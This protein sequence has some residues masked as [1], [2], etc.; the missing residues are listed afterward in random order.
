MASRRAARARAH[1]EAYSSTT[2]VATR[3]RAKAPTKAARPPPPQHRYDDDDDDDDTD[4]TTDSEAAEPFPFFALPAEIRLRVYELLLA[5]PGVVDLNP[6][7]YRTIRRRTLPLFLTSHRMHEEAYRVFY[8]TNVFRIF[9][10]HGRFF[11]TK[12]PL[13]ARLPSRY[14]NSIARLELRLGPG[15]QGPLPKCWDLSPEGAER[16]GLADLADA[17]SLKVFVECDPASDE[18][19]R[20]FRRS[21]DFFT[22]FCSGLLRNFLPRVPSIEEVQFDGFPSVKQDS[23]LM[24]ELLLQVRGH[25]KRV[26]YGPERGWADKVADLE[27]GIARLHLWAG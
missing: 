5:V 21:D 13:L 14:R 1:T 23:P 4:E 22:V 18:I 17:R 3:R 19:F 12:K 9:P 20:G 6:S 2:T 8:G 16:L 10:L 7:N 25:G 11:H 24:K 15:W 27:S 26:T